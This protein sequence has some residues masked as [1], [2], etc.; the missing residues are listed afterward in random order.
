MMMMMILMMILM[1]MMMMM[2]NTQPMDTDGPV[3]Y[4]ARCG[5]AAFVCTTW[6]LG[7][8]CN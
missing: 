1:M 5:C 7:V 2:N 4:G 8:Y 3:S 6:S